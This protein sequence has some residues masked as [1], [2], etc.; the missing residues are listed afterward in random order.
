L[1][2]EIPINPPGIHDVYIEDIIGV[3]VDIPGTDHVVRGQVA[4]I[5][6]IATTA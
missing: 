4:A 2:V 6:A 3:M 1:I 5:L